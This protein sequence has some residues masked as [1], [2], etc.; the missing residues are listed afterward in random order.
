MPAL[1]GPP[2]DDAG[3]AEALEEPELSGFAVT[4]TVEPASVTTDGFEDVVCEGV[5]EPTVLVGVEDDV[6]ESG[7]ADALTA[8][9]LSQTLQYPEAAPPIPMLAKTKYLEFCLT[10]TYQF[11]NRHMERCKMSRTLVMR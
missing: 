7:A 5:V 9:P 10:Y 2:L 8:T 4:I 3:L 6:V 1:L 11:H